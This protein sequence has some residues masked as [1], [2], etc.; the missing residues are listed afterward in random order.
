MCDFPR[1]GPREHQIGPNSRLRFASFRPELDVIRGSTR[2][3]L[4]IDLQILSMR[5][6][7][8]EKFTRC[9]SV[10]ADISFQP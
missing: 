2:V 10:R 7:L 8:V 9:L 4:P 5:V 1:F 6:L 3:V